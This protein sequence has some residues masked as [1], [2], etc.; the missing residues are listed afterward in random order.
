[1]TRIKRWLQNLTT[2]NEAFG[3]KEVR[4]FADSDIPKV[5]NNRGET[6]VVLARH[7]AEAIFGCG[8]VLANYVKNGCVVK[9]IC[10]TDGSRETR[11]G[12]RDKGIIDKIER[13]TIDAAKFI[14]ETVELGF[15]RFA[16]NNLSANKT[17]VGLLKSVLDKTMPGEIFIP[18]I[19]S[20]CDDDLAIVSMLYQAIDDSKTLSHFN[21]WQYEGRNPLPANK[22]VD[23]VDSNWEQKI[24][25]LSSCVNQSA[26]FDYAE[27]AKGLVMYRGCSRR[28]KIE[29]FSVISKDQF[30]KLC[31]LLKP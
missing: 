21:I 16:D 6:V 26:L 28:F 27:A 7:G 9:L 22:F 25:A 19:T 8:G 23:V 10:L 3:W 5:V 18:S 20:G 2:L 29:A 11:S 30:I 13:D 31:R 17:T 12:H 1:M 24:K 4:L 14:G 15:W